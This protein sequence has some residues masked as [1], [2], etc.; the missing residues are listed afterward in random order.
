[1][2]EAGLPSPKFQVYIVAL[3]EVFVNETFNGAHPDVVGA[4][5]LTTGVEFTTTDCVVLAV[6]PE[7]SVTVNVTVYEFADA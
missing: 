3:V 7:L 4:E 5:K 1:V 2:E 6:Q